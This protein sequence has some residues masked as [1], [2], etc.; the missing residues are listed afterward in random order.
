M[1]SAMRVLIVG[2][3]VAALEA[4]LALRRLAEER[5][6][7]VLVSP[8]KAFSYRPLSVAEPFGL[9]AERHFDLAEIAADAG[10]EL[11]D[12]RVCAVDAAAHTVATDSGSSL[13][14]DALVIAC[15]ARRRAPFPEALTFWGRGGC[16]QMTELLED[17]EG[18]WV[19]SVAFALPGGCGWPL[20]LYEL[21][22][23]TSSHL[24]AEG[25][26]G[27]ELMI[28]TPEVAPLE[29]F[30]PEASDRIRRLLS[31]RGIGLFTGSRPSAFRPGELSLEPAGAL[32]VERMVTLPRLEGPGIAGLPAG[33]HGFIPVDL[34]GRVPGL[35]GVYAAGD[36]TTVPIKQGG[37]AAQLADTV[38]AEIA[39]SA[40]AA[41]EQDPFHPVLRG[42]LLTGETPRYLR[43]DFEE[44]AGEV[45]TIADHALWW[46]PSKIAGRHLAP[47]LAT[48]VTSEPDRPVPTARERIPVEIAVDATALTDGR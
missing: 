2:G 41:V 23:L 19:T 47:Y 13:E 4:V 45:S 17:L 43:A 3:G 15:G 9:G 35:A 42:M 48:L 11:R 8:E 20:P 36:A 10:A 38:A 39:L 46:P 37:L 22:L 6:E 1:L 34:H 16:D 31:R 14:Y 5:V 18:G 30:G 33:P 29:V 40:G 24:E 27:V 7:I 32:R 28:V 12:G 44:G 26:H 21:A 25:E